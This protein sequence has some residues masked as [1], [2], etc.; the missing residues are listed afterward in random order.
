[1]LYEAKIVVAL[2]SDYLTPVRGLSCENQVK[3]LILQGL[4][5]LPAT[6]RFVHVLYASVFIL[7]HVAPLF[8]P[9][10]LPVFDIRRLVTNL[11]FVCSAL[12]FSD[13][14][15]LVLFL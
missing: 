13:K 4:R 6:I 10:S 11:I 3:I 14:I 7:Y 8:I 12:S 5:L 2:D 1:M 15:S 9:I